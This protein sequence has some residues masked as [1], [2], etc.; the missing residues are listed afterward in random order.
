MKKVILLFLIAAVMF[1][2]KKNETTKP[3]VKKEA[4]VSFNITTILPDAGRDWEYDIPQCLDDATPV[5]AKIKIDEIE[6]PDAGPG[7]A[8]TTGY[9]DV[10]VFWTNDNL[11]T[12]TFKLPVDPADCL[13]GVCCT[14]YTITEFY[15][16]DAD[17]VMIKAAPAP[18]SE[19]Q[20]FVD[21][22]HA[23]NLTF[24][25][26]AFDK[27]E[28]PIDVLCFEPDFYDLFGFFWFEITEITVRELCFFGDV[29]QDWWLDNMYVPLTAWEDY[30]NYY[31]YQSNGIQTDM[32]AIII[33][34]LYKEIDGQYV[35]IR[36]WDNIYYPDQSYWLGEDVPLCIRYADYDH[37][38]DNF[39]VEMYIYGP[40]NIPYRD[41]EFG[42]TDDNPQMTW[43]WTDG[44]VSGIDLNGD[45]VVE[46]AWGDC[47][48]NPEWH[49]PTQP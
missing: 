13:D 11:Y 29:C 36:F 40:R 17:G 42:F 44:D 10:P 19:F 20:E 41:N 39:M 24:M 38:T 34:K 16:Y 7:G 49:L 48:Q 4:E 22:D 37:E 26:C 35:Y 1:S 15:L 18:G 47:V 21:P 45:G 3:D 32:P 23:L 2:C 31:Q 9:F 25:V 33:I 6:G 5:Y 28:V 27:V 14:T 8:P 30:D 43:T 12:Q 46:F